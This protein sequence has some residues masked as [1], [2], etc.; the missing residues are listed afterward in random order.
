MSILLKF[1]YLTLP[2]TYFTLIILSFFNV[3]FPFY[4][5][6]FS[7]GLIFLSLIVFPR[8]ISYGIDT[9][10]WVGT[11][12]M[13]SGV[14]SLLIS[15]YNLSVFYCISGFLMCFALSSLI[16]FVFFRQLF[17]FKIFTNL[18]LFAIIIFVYI[19]G[20]IPLWLAITCISCL[21]VVVSTGAITAI[22][23]NTRKI[24]TFQSKKMDMIQLKLM[25]I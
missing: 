25:N 5:N 11:L 10:L 20:L 2:L 6:W 13:L 9:N 15:N 14:F 24:W 17:H 1:Y 12:L 4:E 3:I 21:F 22:L 18:T 16:M 7:F 23:K 19:S 8:F